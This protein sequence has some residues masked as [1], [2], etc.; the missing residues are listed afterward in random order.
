MASKSPEKKGS[1]N[2]H[3]ENYV[4][5]EEGDNDAKKLEKHKKAYL[6]SYALNSNIDLKVKDGLFTKKINPIVSLSFDRRV[7][8][9]RDLRDEE[10]KKQEEIVARNRKKSEKSDR[11][12]RVAAA[13]MEAQ[14]GLKGKEAKEKEVHLSK[15]AKQLEISKQNEERKKRGDFEYIPGSVI[16]IKDMPESAASRFIK[17]K[18]ETKKRGFSKLSKI[19]SGGKRKRRKTKRRKRRKT[20]RKKRRKRRKTRRKRK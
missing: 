15:M 18:E 20:K 2:N 16:P 11:T 12:K 19:A 1:L 8:A 6:K 9:E 14:T 3:I 5:E 7:N 17:R 10:L 13:I 4:N